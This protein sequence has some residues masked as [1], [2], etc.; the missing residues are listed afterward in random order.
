M[1]R[2]TFLTATLSASRSNKVARVDPSWIYARD[3]SSILPRLLRP[4]HQASFPV[5]DVATQRGFCLHAR[6]DLGLIEE[7]AVDLIAIPDAIGRME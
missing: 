5:R 4:R 6:D 1:E 7:I 2:S 3:R